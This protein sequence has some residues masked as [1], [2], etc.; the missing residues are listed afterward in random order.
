MATQRPPQRP[1]PHHGHQ[2]P[3]R[4][5]GG[6]PP[7][8]LPMRRLVPDNVDQFLG[9]RLPKTPPAL[10]LNR[11]AWGFPGALPTKNKEKAAE[12]T[13]REAVAALQDFHA[14]LEASI[15]RRK[16]VLEGCG[17]PWA[18][19]TLKTASRLLVGLGIDA[20][21]EIGFSFHY[22]HGGPLLPGSALKG[23]ARS[24][25][26][27]LGEL[28]DTTP[29][30][31]EL[32]GEQDHSGSVGFLD[33]IAIKPKLEI[34]ILNPHVPDYYAGKA[35]V[36]HD[37]ENPVP[38]KFLAVAV[39]VEVRFD[40]VGR[41]GSSQ[42]QVDQAMNWLVQGLTILGAG[43]KTTAGYGVF[44]PT[45]SSFATTSSRAPAPSTQAPPPA[46]EE[47]SPVTLRWNPGNTQLSVEHQGKRAF[48]QQKAAQDL[49]ASLPQERAD[50]LRSKK[51]LERV[52]VKVTRQGNQFSIDQILTPSF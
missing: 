21:H 51:T 39:G 25:A 7:A 50:R 34:D 19:R 12:K 16:S 5:G 15:Q 4:G 6:P 20:P 49:I 40:V 37:A 52:T 23:L 45:S 17:R 28:A 1:Q 8:V 9:D 47:W 32:F 18:S 29:G 48:A 46:R 3:R 44:E 14:L 43:A 2:E 27:D 11:F 13:L 31:L 22:V 38:V 24:A 10:W 33:A 35:S 30:V 41:L 42:Q 36:A 26:R